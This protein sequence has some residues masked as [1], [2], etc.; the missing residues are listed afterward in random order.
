MSNFTMSYKTLNNFVTSC[1]IWSVQKKPY[2]L[3]LLPF[4][5]SLGSSNR[6]FPCLSVAMT[7]INCANAAK[8]ERQ[9]I[10]IDGAV[11]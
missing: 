11:S 7:C 8:E 5:F 4:F 3:I 9:V 10:P 6:I 1:S 2:F